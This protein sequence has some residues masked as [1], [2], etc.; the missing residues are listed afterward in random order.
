MRFCGHK[1][2]QASAGETGIYITDHMAV[3]WALSEQVVQCSECWDH[4][5]GWH[6]L[7]LETRG[8]KGS[9]EQITTGLSPGR[10]KFTHLERV[11][12]AEETPLFQLSMAA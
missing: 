1:A 5:N 8:P 11:G 9:T 7:E 2:E 12:P 10:Q 3:G 4:S 6:H